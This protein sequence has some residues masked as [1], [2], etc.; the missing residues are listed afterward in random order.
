M[1]KKS[2]A[3][4][5]VL[6]IA[7]LTI[8]LNTDAFTDTGTDTGKDTV[9]DGEREVVIKPSN[10][11]LKVNDTGFTER[12]FTNTEPVNIVTFT[13]RIGESEGRLTGYK[14]DP[15]SLREGEGEGLEKLWEDAG[16]NTKVDVMKYVGN[17]LHIARNSDSFALIDEQNGVIESKTLTR[18]NTNIRSGSPYFTITP[19]FNRDE[20]EIWKATS[21]GFEKRRSINTDRTWEVASVNSDASKLFTVATSGETRIWSLKDGDGSSTLGYDRSSMD[22][23]SVEGYNFFELESFDAMRKAVFVDEGTVILGGVTSIFKFDVEDEEW[24]KIHSDATLTSN[25]VWQRDGVI[26][27]VKFDEELTA[28]TIDVD[29]N[30]LMTRVLNS[31]NWSFMGLV[32]DGFVSVEDDNLLSFFET[33]EPTFSVS[34]GER[35]E[36]TR[37]VSVSQ[38]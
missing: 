12:W 32:N 15:D 14:A 20:V 27:F 21:N 17:G 16:F 38:Q 6:I 29:G 9:S 18:G 4:L 23:T 33:D 7:L 3:I 24:S 35:L 8:G 19:S 1:I 11:S 34:V 30:V 10:T 13:Q 28:Y 37:G 22:L 36:N 2:T 25:T 31:D 5:T 26:G